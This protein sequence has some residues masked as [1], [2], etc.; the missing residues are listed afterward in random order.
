MVNNRMFIAQLSDTH[1]NSIT[2]SSKLEDD[3]SFHREELIEYKSY[4]KKAKHFF[5]KGELVEAYHHYGIAKNIAVNILWYEAEAHCLMAIG[6][7]NTIWK[8][9]DTAYKNYMRCLNIVLDKE[10]ND[11]LSLE[12]IIN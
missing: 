7:I 12:I 10:L 5:R 4:I 6:T 9:F 2:T 11:S 8:K 1:E 3:V